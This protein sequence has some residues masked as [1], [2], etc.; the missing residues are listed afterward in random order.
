MLACLVYL[1]TLVTLVTLCCSLAALLDD[2]C[3]VSVYCCLPDCAWML[4]AH[5]SCHAPSVVLLSSVI[6][7]VWCPVS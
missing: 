7:L 5:D 3:V 1:V 6:C 4:T 2:A